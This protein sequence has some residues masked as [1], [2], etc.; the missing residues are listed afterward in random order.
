MSVNR[1]E[2]ASG[3]LVGLLFIPVLNFSLNFLASL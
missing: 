1:Y 2:L 3:I